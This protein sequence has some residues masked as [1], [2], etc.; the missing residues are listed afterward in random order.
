MDNNKTID[1][2]IEEK[3]FLVIYVLNRWYVQHLGDE[4]FF[5]IGLIALWNAIKSFDETKGAKF[6]TYAIIC[7]KRAISGEIVRLNRKKFGA[8]NEI[9]W[10]DSNKFENPK[11]DPLPSLKETLVDE[12]MSVEDTVAFEDAV[13]KLDDVE[14][15][16]V[17]AKLNKMGEGRIESALGISKYKSRKA[18]DSAKRKFSEMYKGK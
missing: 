3:S 10:L 4:D 16:V 2:I 7:I 17:F 1:E 9:L 8:N 18:W 15:K 12:S 5:Q 14:R 11:G 13:N 6:D